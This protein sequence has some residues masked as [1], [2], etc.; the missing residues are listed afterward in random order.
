MKHITSKIPIIVV[1]L[2]GIGIL[3][4]LQSTL[5]Q[6]I[7][8][9]GFAFGNGRTEATEV[10][11]SSKL[12]GRIA[13][14][15]VDEGDLVEANQIVARLDRRELQARY[16]QAKAQISQARQEQ[17]FAEAV[18]LQ[19]KSELAL[20]RKIL[21]RSKRLYE[22]K[23]IALERLQ[24]NETNVQTALAALSAAK[25]QVVSAKAAEVAAKAQAETIETNLDDCVLHSPINGRVLYRL[26][27]PGEVLGVGGKVLT[28][29]NLSDVYM[30][31][32]LPTSD[33]GKVVIGAD[34]RIVLD[35][36][37]TQPLAAKVTFVAPRAQFTP[38]E[39]ETRS[40]RE[41]LMFRI[42][43][44]INREALNETLKIGM[45]GVAYIRLSKSLP[46]PQ[47]LQ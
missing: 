29:L 3:G 38:R 24:Q 30:T 5:R 8:L 11:V 15:T 10:D 31:V 14:I 1:A 22:N 44:N 27:E 37:E 19:R 21:S 6:E 47:H 36:Q 35:A 39:V 17:A 20:A 2:L 7:E 32:F 43:V 46:W 28:V 41:K 16:R 40:E 9:Q 33:A 12:A 25:A 18:V 26:A 42:K 4:L 23:S 13:D 45:P 34:A